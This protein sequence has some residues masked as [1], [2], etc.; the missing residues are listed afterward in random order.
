MKAHGREVVTQSENYLQIIAINFT[1]N[2]P[3]RL[4]NLTKNTRKTGLR[5]QLTSNFKHKIIRCT[6]LFQIGYKCHWMTK[7]TG[8]TYAQ[9]EA[10][11]AVLDLSSQNRFTCSISV[12]VRC[13]SIKE[14]LMLAVTF[15][16]PCAF[17]SIVSLFT[18]F[19]Q[20]QS[21]L[22]LLTAHLG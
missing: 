3:E 15:N 16:M 9:L 18:V 17:W 1:Q 8:S 10:S 22:A 7:N 2:S 13:M 20:S 6:D 19:S 4:V 5:I 12:P 14:N 21:I 11:D